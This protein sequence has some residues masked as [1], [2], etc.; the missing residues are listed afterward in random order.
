MAGPDRIYDVDLDELPPTPELIRKLRAVQV[1][2]RAARLVASWVEMKRL[3]IDVECSKRTEVRYRKALVAALGKPVPPRP[4][5]AY[6]DQ[7][8]PL[9]D[10]GHADVVAT[11]SMGL[12]ALAVLATLYGA[13]GGPDVSWL[14][15]V[16]A[17]GQCWFCQVERR[18]D[19]TFVVT[20]VD[21][22]APAVAA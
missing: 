21:E 18:A 9:R 3:G 6:V 13:Q 16:V 2:P 11:G 10:A 12:V 19:G 8:V 20:L 22:L 14:A 4:G 7:A 15:F 1:T 5:R 17:R